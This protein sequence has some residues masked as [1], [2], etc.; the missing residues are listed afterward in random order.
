MACLEIT[1]H[2]SKNTLCQ[3][4]LGEPFLVFKVGRSHKP[5]PLSS[6]THRLF[7]LVGTWHRDCHSSRF[8]SC[9]YRMML[10]GACSVFSIDGV[11]T[12]RFSALWGSP[13]WVFLVQSASKL[14]DVLGIFQQTSVT[15]TRLLYMLRLLHLMAVL[16]D[17]TLIIQR[18]SMQSPVYFSQQT[19]KEWWIPS[20]FLAQN[21]VSSFLCWGSGAVTFMLIDFSWLFNGWKKMLS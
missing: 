17:V 16:N 15:Y 7:Y 5:P 4:P 12:D 3:R 8:W 19:A 11:G 6:D 20:V 13:V 14:C 2:C 18:D 1:F 21:L 9:A 10:V